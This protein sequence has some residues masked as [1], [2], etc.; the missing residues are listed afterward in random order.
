MARLLPHPALHRLCQARNG[1][2]IERKRGPSRSGPVKQSMKILA[3]V[4]WAC[5]A[6]L[7]LIFLSPVAAVAEEPKESTTQVPQEPRAYQ[8]T[9]TLSP[10][11]PDE[12]LRGEYSAEAAAG[13]LD[14]V[15]VAWQRE[16]KCFA[17]HANFA[18]LLARPAVSWDVPVYHQIRAAAER[19]A[20]V[21]ACRPMNPGDRARP[22]WSG[23]HP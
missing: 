17:C 1:T 12:P 5:C 16:Q 22:C 6:Y 2:D 3:R 4:Q 7:L 10:I 20:R 9:V 8:E 18:Y 13:Y 14:G 19:I 11:T 21:K 15:A 23:R